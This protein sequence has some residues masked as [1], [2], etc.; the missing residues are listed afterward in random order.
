M[1]QEAV[2][3][4]RR[5]LRVLSL[6]LFAAVGSTL[7]MRYAPGYFVDS[8]EMDAAHAESART[9]IRVLQAEQGSFPL[10]LKSQLRDWV[11]GDLG[12]SRHYD[13]PVS[14]LL[15]ERSAT[16]VRLLLRGLGTGWLVALALALP[17]SGRRTGKGELLI[18]GSTA[19]L[20]A[21]PVGVLATLSLLANAGGPALVLALLIAVRD[22]K[23]L[24]RLLRSTWHAPYLL[25]A[26][27]QGFSFA[28]AARVH[29]LPVLGSELLAIAMMSLVVALSGLVPVE[30]IFDVPGLGQL[31]WSAALNRDLPVLVA[32]TVLLALCIG[33]AGLFA[34]GNQSPEAAQCV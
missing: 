13:L 3:W 17:L 11:H 14:Q 25:H 22:F 15:R 7:L 30:V 1:R 26:R 12:H 27:S 8:R 19:A 2:S 23:L 5:L 10:L 32:V 4:V 34:T 21:V 16:T 29:L 9:E 31:A 20:L 18:T 6:V 28:H 24:Y 33:V